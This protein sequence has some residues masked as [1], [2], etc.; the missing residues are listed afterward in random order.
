[1][2]K[3]YKWCLFTFLAVF[4]L[5]TNAAADTSVS[6]RLRTYLYGWQSF[7]PEEQS[8]LRLY[9]SLILNVNGL[10]VKNLSFHSYMR[11]THDFQSDEEIHAPTRLFNGYLN[12]KNIGGLLDLRMGRQFVD[13]GVGSV[14]LDGLKATVTKH[15]AFVFSVIFGAE[16]PFTREMELQ[17]F[18][19]HSVLGAY[20]STAYFLDTRIGLSYIQKKREGR[21]RWKQA[22]LTID[23]TLSSGITFMGKCD[24]NLDTREIHELLARVRFTPGQ[25]FSLYSDFGRRKPRIDSDSFFNIFDPQPYDWFRLGGNYQIMEG[26]T[27]HADYRLTELETDQSSRLA[28]GVDIG[29]FDIGITNQSGYAGNQFGAYCGVERDF[30]DRLSLGA[31]MN[32]SRFSLEELVGDMENAL[33]S[34][35]RVSYLP[36]NG[37]RTDLSVQHLTNPQYRKDLRVL[38]TI[39]YSFRHG[40]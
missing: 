16:A 18:S 9:Q 11:T 14:T 2:K 3:I 30:G 36:L 31:R 29:I 4:V 37:L 32:F 23:K 7:I 1:M 22:G 13:F 33:Y 20:L 6:G 24:Y 26:T 10:G 39:S 12:L 34:Y 25:R 35:L 38:G 27:V 28:L 40:R 5:S 15:R 21:I 8:H 19:N 17:S